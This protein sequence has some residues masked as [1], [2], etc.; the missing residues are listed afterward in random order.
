MDISFS[1]QTQE[2]GSINS[3]NVRIA[4]AGTGLHNQRGR[5]I[6]SVVFK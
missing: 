4:F 2:V 1:K 5:S 6:I 3:Q